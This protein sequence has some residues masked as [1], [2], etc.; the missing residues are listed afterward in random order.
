MRKKKKNIGKIPLFIIVANVVFIS[1]FIVD[2]HRL[3][4]QG[5][6]ITDIN[7]ANLMIQMDETVDSRYV[8]K[9][10]TIISTQRYGSE[11]MADLNS[12]TWYLTDNIANTDKYE[13]G[14]SKITIYTD[15]NFT[16]NVKEILDELE[17]GDANVN[18]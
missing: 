2:K 18:G 5:D 12:Y 15:D 4:D 3:L 6:K 1:I 13:I 14:N 16:S 9:L 10:E 17:K 8:G 7:K 11:M